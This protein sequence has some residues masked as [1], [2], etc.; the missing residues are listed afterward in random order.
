MILFRRIAVVTAAF[1]LSQAGASVG[2]QKPSGSADATAAGD[3]L[4]PDF[5][6]R[7][8][9]SGTH[10]GRV[11]TPGPMPRR[12]DLRSIAR[13]A[14][15]TREYGGAYELV[16][17][18]DGNALSGRVSGT[19]GL[20]P[21][22][23]SGTRRGDRCR[24]IDDRYGTITE[25]RC[26][27]AGFTGTARTQP[28][29]RQNM[30]MEIDASA[31]QFIDAAQEAREPLVA[32][33]A[34]RQA[35]RRAPP[36]PTRAIPAAPSAPARDLPRHADGTPVV[37]PAAL[38]VSLD[39]LL[40]RLVRMD[41][42]TWHMNQYVQN[43]MRNAR[44]EQTNRGHT[45]FIARGTYSYR[46]QSGASAPQQGWVR[47]WIQDGR[48][49]CIEFHD[50]AGDCRPLNQNPSQMILGAMAE[51]LMNMSLRDMGAGIC[52]RV[53]A[54]RGIPVITPRAC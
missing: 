22:T 47:V 37:T 19:G 25:A 13:A 23:L 32:A 53:D 24:L 5:R 8:T 38:G 29:S 45:S 4:P 28:G 49:R 27:A 6:G 7:I 20:L 35:A 16:L 44:Y 1:L 26:T 2:A 46:S 21:T 15:R 42:L 18:F 31:V 3:V 34:E 43:S 14:G 12:L 41:A 39:E 54:G 33:E 10:E 30:T 51:G 52:A 48:F 9:Y 40:N 50:V 36:P 17:E 11:T